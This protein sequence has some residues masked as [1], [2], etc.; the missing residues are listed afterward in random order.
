MH[1]VFVI[2]HSAFNIQHFVP[3]RVAN[4]EW[5]TMTDEFYMQH[6][7][8]LAERGRYSVSPNPMVGC[9]LVRDGAV[10][11]E[12]WHERAGEAHAE[13]A[14]LAKCGD[15]SGATMYVTLEPCSHHGR[16]PPCAE[17]VVAAGVSRVVIAMRDP[18]DVVDGRGIELLRAAG[19]AVEVGLCESDA[20]RLNEKFVWSVT[21]RLPFVLIKA[22][23]TLDAKLATITRQSQW[24]TSE[25]ARER[26]LR[27]REEY[28]AILIG[29]GTVRADD[30][31]LSRRLGLASGITPWTRIVLDGDADLPPHAQLLRDG[32]RT[33]LFTRD[34]H[35]YE[36]SQGLE[37]IESPG[38]SDIESI[39]AAAYE[40]GI[41]SILVEG[42]S[43][44]IGQFLLLSL[45]QKLTLFIAP[46]IVGGSEAP[47]LYSGSA[48]ERLTDAHRFR[49]DRA[50]FAGEDLMLT[51]YPH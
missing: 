36:P 18:H 22:G 45:W 51:A 43:H 27:L 29:S 42:G 10:L 7:L 49:F 25:E 3:W 34:G 1:I 20:R 40:R 11:A 23:M 33:L 48:I 19:I 31:R 41:R 14:A 12:A 46:M 16:T 26:S 24:I 44:V 30:P 9:V 2:Q 37:I 5:E 38:R 15:A 39:L 6:A 21:H 17:A 35:R 32:G 28:D 8:A 50:E 47:S 13:V 4:I